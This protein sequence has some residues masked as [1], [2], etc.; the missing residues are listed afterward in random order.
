MGNEEWRTVLDAHL[1]GAFLYSRAAQKHM[2]EQGYGQDSERRAR[3]L[4]RIDAHP[5]GEAKPPTWR[6]GPKMGHLADV[7]GTSP[8]HHGDRRGGRA[9]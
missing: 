2:V 7:L 5:V 3:P 9:D 1:T 4:R 8:K 6:I